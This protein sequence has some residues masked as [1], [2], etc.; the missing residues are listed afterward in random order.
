M[1][2]NFRFHTNTLRCR[3]DNLTIDELH[4]QFW[5]DYDELEYGHGYIQ[6]LF[7]I[8]EHGMNYAA[9]PL[10]RHEI[11]LMSGSK[12]IMRRVWTS[13]EMML[14]FYG[15]RIVEPRTGLLERTENYRSRYR[16]LLRSPHNNLR[17]TRI[18]KCLSELG[19][20][21]ASAGFLLHLLCEQSSKDQLNTAGIKGSMDGWWV[22]C[23]R[24]EHERLW[25]TTLVEDVRSGKR[26]FTRE[27][28][29]RV[30][31]V[32]DKTGHLD[33]GV[34]DLA[35]E[36]D[37]KEDRGKAREDE[38]GDN[39]RPIHRRVRRD[40]FDAPDPRSPRKEQQEASPRRSNNSASPS[41][42]THSRQS[43]WSG[44]NSRNG[45]RSRP[46]TPEAKDQVSPLLDHTEHDAPMDTS[47]RTVASQNEN[48]S[49][50]ANQ[51][52]SM[53]SVD[54]EE[55]KEVERV[56]GAAEQSDEREN[57]LASR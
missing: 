43:N 54:G 18:L 14:D 33:W 56:V 27:D 40:S 34:E 50:T 45:S 42:S 19:I 55:M 32:R 41:P 26:R 7:P 51:D 35:E 5:G 28:Y 37:Q 36:N 46:S 48:K 49:P 4:Q 9:Q 31:A 25:V 21:Y 30:L 22:H 10:Q 53:E 15:M 12:E 17:I 52:E 20:E 47:E 11:E 57:G 38:T 8:R 24:N 16:N 13:Y 3:P 39:S 44:I 2:R 6:W 1:D 29:E 23:I